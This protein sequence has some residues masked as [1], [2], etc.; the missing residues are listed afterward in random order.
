MRFKSGDFFMHKRAKIIIGIAA[1]VL[2]LILAV[3]GYNLLSKKVKPQQNTAA[4]SSEI[5]KTSAPDFTVQDTNGMNVSLSD[6]KGKPVVLNFWASWCPP[7][8]A[9][10]PD[11]EKM[12]QQYS[13]KGVIFMM[14]NLTDGVRET[15]ATAKQFLYDNKYTF[16][17][18]FDMKL[19]AANTYGISSIPNS[20]F[21]D[22]DGDIENTFEGMI[23]AATI[24]KNIE[25]IMK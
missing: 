3:V 16:P 24:K 5:P 14:V 23:D 1:F 19:D 6:F 22:K 9:E 25:A 21:I 18:Y 17:A 10:M 12:V 4:A 15:T 11:Y 2:L 20:I 7:C 13:T 8:K